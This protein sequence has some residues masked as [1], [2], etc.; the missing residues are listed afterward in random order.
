MLL[1]FDSIRVIAGL[2]FLLWASYHDYSTR[3]VPNRVWKLFLPIAIT[4]CILDLYFRGLTIAYAVQTAI[5]IVIPSAIFIILFYLGFYGGADAKAMICLSIAIPNNLHFGAFP[6]WGT[7]PVFPLSVLNNALV[8]SASTFP[9]ALTSNILWKARNKEALFQGLE[10]EPLRKKLFALLFCVKKRKAEVKP[11]DTVAEKTVVG[12]EGKKRS[13]RVS[14]RVADE[15]EESGFDVEELPENI[16]VDFSLP[17]LLFITVGF[18]TSII[19]GDI[20]FW[21]IGEIFHFHF[22]F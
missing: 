3:E 5:S 6:V 21:F 18:A 17:M 22:G 2:G 16:F 11:Y 14:W 12:E 9:Y 19:L 20:I 13:I 15:E 10:E 1:I 8:F 4:F 7:L